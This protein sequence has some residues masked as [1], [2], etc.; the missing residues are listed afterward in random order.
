MNDI[1]IC[2]LGGDSRMVSAARFMCKQNYSV[3]VFG[4][5]GI[6]T[7]ATICNDLES[8]VTGASLIVLPLPFS[9]DGIKLF[10]PL[11]N[12][13]IK[14]SDIIS[15]LKNGQLVTGGKLSEDFCKKVVQNGCASFD[16]Y[17]S[18]RLSVLNAIPTAEGA[19]SIAINE[20]TKTIFGSKCVI[21][22]YGRIGK[23]LAKLLKNMGADVTVF[24]RSEQALTW[25]EADGCHA[26]TFCCANRHLNDKDIIFNTIPALWMNKNI[27]DSTKSDAVIIDL[28]STPGGV[29]FEYAKSV[30]KKVIFALSLPGK[31]AP[32]SAGNIIADCVL[33]KLKGGLL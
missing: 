22:G 20:T 8:A 31:V 12:F 32:E 2:V 19:V 15:L 4:I 25:A 5:N 14:I 7:E 24:A 16:Y 27:I 1:K 11:C 17:L 18:E 10:A 6:V 13:E 21:A 30:S 23:I 9:T 33:S 29:D 28:A 26:C 3:S